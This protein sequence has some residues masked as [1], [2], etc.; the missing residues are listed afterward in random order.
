MLKL[1]QVC[2]EVRPA[3]DEEL[4]SAYVEDFRY[5]L[6]AMKLCIRFFTPTEMSICLLQDS[7]LNIRGFKCHTGKVSH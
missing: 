3:L 2:T 1:V 4:P 7:W 6:F 5:A